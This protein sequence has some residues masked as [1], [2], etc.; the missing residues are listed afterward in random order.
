MYEVTNF[1]KTCRNNERMALYGCMA[2]RLC[3]TVI[4]LILSVPVAIR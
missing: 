1:T 2:V 4:H 3:I